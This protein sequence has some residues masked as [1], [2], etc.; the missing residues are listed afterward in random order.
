MVGCRRS[1]AVPSSIE[2][3]QQHSQR[4]SQ[5]PLSL[6]ALVEAVTYFETEE[7]MLNF[8]EKFCLKQDSYACE[9]SGKEHFAVLKSSTVSATL[10][11]SL[12]FRFQ[13]TCQS[14]R[15]SPAVILVP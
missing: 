4:Y 13:I 9:N 10:E 12:D 3:V 8:R 7:R 11:S 5:P 15:D 2:N 14:D 6:A 1:L